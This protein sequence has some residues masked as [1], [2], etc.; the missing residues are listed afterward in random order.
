M[1][2]NPFSQ[3]QHFGDIWK[4]LSKDQL[5]RGE[6]MAK[7]WEAHEA[8]S[9]ERA[10][11]MFDESARLAR[12]SLAYQQKLAADWRKLAFDSIKKAG[13]AFGA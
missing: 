13:E 7:E 12:E 1:F 10:T 9:Y 3:P 2:W 11:Q 8:K 4:T 6:A 5:A